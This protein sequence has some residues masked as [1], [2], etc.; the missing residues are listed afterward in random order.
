MSETIFLS[1]DAMGG[2]TAPEV[3]IDGLVKYCATRS[4]VAF[5]LHGD[6]AKIAP[7]LAAHPQTAARCTIHHTEG[8]IASDVKPS[9]ALR[10]GK[11]SSMWNAVQAVKEGRTGAA[12]SAG[13]TGALMAI[14]MVILRKMAGVHRPG[15]TAL[16]P[17]IT[18]TH[19]VVLDVGANLEATASQLVIYAIMGEA[20]ARAIHNTAAPTIG[21]LNIGTE[22][23]KGHDEVKA[24][25]EML[26][27]ESLKLDYRGFVEGN[28][29]S[30]HKVDVVVTDGFTGN[31][32]LKAGEGVAHLVSTMVKQAL[33]KNALTKAGALIASSG[34]KDLKERMNPSN[35]NGGVLLGLNGVVVKSHGGTDADGFATAIRLAAR[36]ARSKYM[37]EV[38]SNLKRFSAAEDIAA[39]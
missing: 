19:T 23:M 4:D 20:Y 21:L 10:R 29:L 9:Q 35:A 28:D 7:L 38:A 22:E 25:H 15:M 36:L 16:W 24:A 8:Y 13:N 26:K 1:I 34:L 6:E 30:M 11:G 39:E 5:E 32:A 14:S 18:G 17:T 3:V 31:V 37:E 2:D 12:V 27:D 33:T